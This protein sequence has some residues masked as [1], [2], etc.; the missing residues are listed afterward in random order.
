MANILF[1][2]NFDSFTYNL[3]D[4]FRVL[5]HNVTVY[6]NDCELD[7]LIKA[8]TAQ[9]DTILALSPGPGNPQQA[10]NMLPLINALKHQ[11]P[12]IGICL[13]HQAIIEAFG[14]EIVHAGEVMHGKVSKIT[15][16][17]QAMF[18]G[19][20][21][22]LSVARYHS[23]IGSNLPSELIVNAEYHH[24]VMAVRHQSLPI[25]GFQFHPESI[26]TV[27][28]GQLL[29]QTIDWLLAH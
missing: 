28:G 18:A 12:I 8:A 10:G 27:Q 22:P 29:K 3:V 15:H 9:P 20:P 13:G 21:N 26:L 4:Q 23:L 6:R 16:D 24:I 7:T 5:G 19:L 25:C 1:L 17:N 14:G 11:C 2:D